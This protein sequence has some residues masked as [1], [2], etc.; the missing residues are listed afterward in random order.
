[1]GYISMLHYLGDGLFNLIGLFV[2]GLD[3]LAS[4]KCHDSL[5]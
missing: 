3:D 2:V 4:G 5:L 1:M